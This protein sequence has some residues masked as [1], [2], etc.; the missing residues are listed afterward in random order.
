MKIT[1]KSK[2]QTRLPKAGE[3]WKSHDKE[4]AGEV[5]LIVELGKYGSAKSHLA[6]ILLNDPDG[7]WK[8]YEKNGITTTW[9]GKDRLDTKNFALYFHFVCN[10][11]DAK[12]ILP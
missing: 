1:Y 6:A 8:R 7:L 9:S 2:E 4:W 10:I 5:Y 12:L 3:I 11:E